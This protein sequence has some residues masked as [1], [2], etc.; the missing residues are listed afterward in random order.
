MVDLVE[1]AEA[2]EMP[3]GYRMTELGLLPEDWRV[4]PLGLI[5]PM[6]L[7]RTPAR[8]TSPYW[9]DGCVPWVSIADLNNGRVT[10]TRESISRRAFDEVFR[11]RIVQEGSLLMSF[12]L[13]IG[14]VGIL[15]IPAVHNEAIASFLPGS[16]IDRDFLFFLL[17]ATDFTRSVDS[18]VKG[19]TL[20]KDKMQRFLLPVPPLAEQR[21]IA[22]VL[23]TVQ[24]AREAT[25]AVIATTRELKRSLMR[26]LFTYGPVPLDQVAGVRLKETEIGLVPEQ[27]QVERFDDLVTIVGGQVDPTQAPFSTLPHVAPDH[28][29]SGTGRLLPT[30]TA[31]E[32]NLISGKYHFA[33]GDVLYSKIRP[34]LCKAALVRFEGTCSA[35]MYVLRPVANRLARAFLFYLLLTP[36]FT[37]Q[38]MSF[39]DRTGIPK[40]NRQ[41]LGTLL[42]PV[43]RD[44]EQR[45]IAATYA[46]AD[47]KLRVEGAVAKQCDDLFRAL[48]GKLVTGQVRAIER[49]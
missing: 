23:S 3:A 44:D 28:I 35:D 46:A 27:W 38:A 47:A 32:L 11:G 7:G 41:Q 5:A 18:Y 20:N 29:E 17:Q 33:A 30:R 24:R 43:P 16:S 31:R 42:L 26:H 13:T 22:Q 4:L 15:D 12:K 2:D 25:E 48:L 34:Y 8:A 45:K 37:R 19:K 40:I 6:Q 49:E 21:A 10:A 1:R 14:K 39:Q 9:N 36:Q